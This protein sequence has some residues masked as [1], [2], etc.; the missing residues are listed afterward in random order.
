MFAERRIV[1]QIFQRNRRSYFKKIDMVL[2]NSSKI[3]FCFLNGFY[4]VSLPFIKWRTTTPD[5]KVLLE[6]SFSLMF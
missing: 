2:V 1:N 4:Q 3:I 6:R 5:G